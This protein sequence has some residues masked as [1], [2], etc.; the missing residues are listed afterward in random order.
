MTSEACTTGKPVYVARLTGGSS[1]FR[2]FHDRLTE[3]GFTRLFDGT[4]GEHPAKR[5]DETAT[6]AAEVRRRLGLTGA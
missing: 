4:L 3:D 6:I 1:K 5:L 2:E